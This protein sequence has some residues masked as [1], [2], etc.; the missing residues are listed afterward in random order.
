MVGFMKEVLVTND[1]EPLTFTTLSTAT[2]RAL[3]KLHRDPGKDQRS[4]KQ[5]SDDIKDNAVAKLGIA[6]IATG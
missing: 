1:N 3:A 6:M 5:N 2:E 4:E